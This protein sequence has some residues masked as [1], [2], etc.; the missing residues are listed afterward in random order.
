MADKFAAELVYLPFI[1]VVS[2]GIMVAVILFLGRNSEEAQYRRECRERREANENQIA[3]EV[4]RAEKLWDEGH[5]HWRHP[6]YAE[7][8]RQQEIELFGLE[9]LEKREQETIKLHKHFEAERER[10]QAKRRTEAEKEEM[11][12]TNHLPLDKQERARRLIRAKY[13][14]MIRRKQR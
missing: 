1:L 4:R 3:K 11:R 14:N 8:K 9:Y 6:N 2:I 10:E 5:L 7:L 12:L 13:S